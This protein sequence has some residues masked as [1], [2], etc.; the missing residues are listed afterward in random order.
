MN[1]GSRLGGDP[2]IGS[3]VT[4]GLGT[5]NENL[6]A[7]VVMTELPLP[8]GGSTNWSNGFLPPYY[9][10]TRLRPEGSP[11]L[12]LKTPAPNAATEK[13]DRRVNETQSTSSRNAPLRM[14]GFRLV[15]Q[16]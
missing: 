15:L 3:W 14:K 5:E 13:N 11:L 10:G 16:T 1:T 2:A 4:Y 8:Q 6:P 7:F 9:Q 12:D